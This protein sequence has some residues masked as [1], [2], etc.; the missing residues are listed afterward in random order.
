MTHAELGQ[1]QLQERESLQCSKGHLS[2]CHCR[3][4]GICTVNHKLIRTRSLPI[5]PDLPTEINEQ[6][7]L[8]AATLKNGDPAG[9]ERIDARGGTLILSGEDIVSINIKRFPMQYAPRPT[10]LGTDSDIGG[11]VGAGGRSGGGVRGPRGSG[12]TA[13]RELQKVS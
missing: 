12:S 3:M 4:W 13:E 7:L 9:K 1:H 2:T 10:G 6:L 11:R 5:R 8:R